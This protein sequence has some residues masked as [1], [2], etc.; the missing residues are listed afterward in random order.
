[1][2]KFF[3]GPMSLNVVDSIVE[4]CNDNN[5][6]IGLIPSR[7]QIDYSSGYVNNWNTFDF[8]NYINERSSNIILQRDHG[9][10]GQGQTMD[11]G[12]LS[13]GIDS[14]CFN[15]IHVDPW[16]SYPEYEE[17]LN[18]SIEYMEFIYSI[19]KDI[20]FEIGT[21]EAIRKF[22][23]DEF[24]KLLRDLKSKCNPEIFENIA[25]A[26]VQS[27]VGLNLGE[28]KN[29]GSFNMKRLKEMVSICN[30]YGLKSKEHNGD[31]LSNNEIK[32][33]F[34]AGLTSINIAPEF[35]QIETLCYL[36]EINNSKTLDKVYQI[37][38]NS[39]KWKKWVSNDSFD[40]KQEKEKLI[41]I[42]CHY[43][44]STPQFLEIK[45][46]IDEKIKNTIKLKLAELYEI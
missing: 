13:F 8:S 9:G 24:E 4:F 30:Y 6:K 20:K 19:N 40:P 18:K 42:C 33:R 7:R 21:E 2:S 45:P 27:G 16:K 39:Y 1:M 43:V 22:N 34:S 41:K 32:K 44:L 28:M 15:L 25:Y 46:D 37:C 17:G 31:Y 14:T 36:N 10:D 35:G 3:I 12:M 26:V 5:K 11:D 38:Y 23:I 29:T